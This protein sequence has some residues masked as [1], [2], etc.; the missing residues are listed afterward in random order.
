M[1]FCHIHHSKIQPLDGECLRDL[2]PTLSCDS[3]V[4]TVGFQPMHF[5]FWRRKRHLGKVFPGVEG[6]GHW[7]QESLTFDQW[8]FW[9]KILS[10]RRKCENLEQKEETQLKFVTQCTL[11]TPTGREVLASLTGNYTTLQEEEKILSYWVKAQ[12]IEEA[13]MHP[14]KSQITSNFQFPP[15]DSLFTKWVFLPFISLD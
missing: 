6:Q 11:L 10:K 15:M 3:N 4:T 14:M 1:C 9:R 7:I 5:P 12:S 8:R 13:M 2:P